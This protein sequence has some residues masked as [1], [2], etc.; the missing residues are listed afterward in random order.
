MEAYRR[1]AEVEMWAGEG[2]A[3]PA[4]AGGRIFGSVRDLEKMA[5]GARAD[6]ALV[7]AAISDFTLRPS[8]GKISSAA[9]RTLSLEPAP[10][11]LGLLR[12]GC[13]KLV[14]FKAETGITAKELE[15]RAGERMKQHNLDMIVAN[16]LEDVRP[17]ETRALVLM[18]GSAPKRFEG[19]KSA[20][21]ELVFNKIAED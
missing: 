19:S 21:A 20:L 17:R 10:K 4:F 14:G 16:L 5:P 15:R 8:V 7:P 9:A 2:V 12:K 3:I 1:G 13:A 11:I 18:P 6:I